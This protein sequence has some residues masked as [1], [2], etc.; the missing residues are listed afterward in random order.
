MDYKMLYAIIELTMKCNMRCMHCGSACKEALEDELTTEEMLNL[1]D[2]LGEMGLKCVTLSGGEPTTRPDWYEIAKRC[3]KNNIYTNMITNGWELDD[4]TLKK[5]EDAGINTLAISID[6]MKETH[7]RI[8]KVGSYEKSMQAFKNMQKYNL[9]PAAITTVHKQNIDQLEDLFKCLKEVGVQTWQIQIALPMGNFKKHEAECIKP[10]DVQTIIDFAYSKIDDDM[11][12]DLADCIGYYSKKE[13]ALNKKRM[14][15]NG[16]WNGCTAGKY[17]IGILC[18]GDV[19]GCTSIRAKEFIE[20]N[21][22]KRPLKEI[23]E[24]EECFKWNRNL[25]K[26]DLKGN[27]K[28]CQYGERCLGGCSNLKYCMFEDVKSENKYCVYHKQIEKYKEYINSISN[29][30]EL[31]QL[32]YD[33]TQKKNYQIALL[34]LNRI[35]QLNL[36]TEQTRKIEAFVCF[37]KKDYKACKDINKAILD[38]NPMN[39]QAKKGYG[40][41]LYKLG[42][43]DEAVMVLYE[44][45]DIDNYDSYND[46]YA[47]LKEQKKDEEAD[48][49]LKMYEE[50][51]KNK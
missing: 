15:K 36:E 31:L 3:V 24:D 14:G 1:C 48:K 29:Y 27:C 49:V 45:L 28:E 16:I 2:D 44:A 37:E 11:M 8:R 23:W 21:I 12:I 32:L 34:I 38:S 10:K 5:A 41:A 35:K 26:E 20:G 47:V 17:S 33:I 25:K 39:L 7:D 18:N 30:E 13:I 43:I 19:V 50:A 40:L 22:R 6:G 4:E 9:V 51:K 42:K 46:L